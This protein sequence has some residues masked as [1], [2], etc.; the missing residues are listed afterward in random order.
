MSHVSDLARLPL[1]WSYYQLSRP[2]RAWRNGRDARAGRSPVAVLF[3]HRIADDR[4][5]PWTCSNRLFA[6]HMRWLKKRFEMISLS[7][8]QHRLRAGSNNR[9]AVSVTFDD[10][11]EDNCREA[12]PL[13]IRE[14]IPCTYFVST[15]FIFRREPFPHDV[16]LGQRLLPNSLTQLRELAAAGI[17]IGA[18]TRTHADLGKVTDPEILKDEVITAGEELQTALRRPVRW[19]AFPFG[20]YENLNPHAFHLAYEAGYEGVCSA[21]GGLNWP[22]DDAFHLQ[23]VHGDADNVRL[24]NWVTVDPRKNATR[25]YEYE[26]ADA[27]ARAPERSAAASVPTRRGNGPPP[28]MAGSGI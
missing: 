5:T 9:I 18:H 19:F 1:L 23:R 22:G 24:K 15:R 14:Q 12:L 6:R 28:D 2:Y 25:R 10:G 3:Y 11:Y 4:A 20:Q 27:P 7:E 26:H 13:L 8:A 17:E 16:A 21:Y